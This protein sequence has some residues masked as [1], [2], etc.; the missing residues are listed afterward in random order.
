MR[1]LM[2]NSGLSCGGAEKQIVE[3]SKEFVRLGRAVAIYTLTAG[4]AH[5]QHLDGRRPQ[6]RFRVIGGRVEGRTVRTIPS[7]E[8]V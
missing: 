3:L 6:H 5:L 2:V 1:I 7:R 4:V 8:Q